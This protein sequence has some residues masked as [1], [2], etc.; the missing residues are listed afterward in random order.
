LILKKGG[1]ICK[2]QILVR[3]DFNEF[4]VIIGAELMRLLESLG[5]DVKEG[6]YVGGKIL[7]KIIK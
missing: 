2:K 5:G 1:K 7:A 3:F 4:G 6:D